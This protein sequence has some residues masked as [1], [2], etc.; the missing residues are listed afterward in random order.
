MKTFS[1]LIL[2]KLCPPE[3]NNHLY[4]CALLRRNKWVLLHA[5]L[6]STHGHSY[7]QESDWKKERLLRQ[8]CYRLLKPWVLN[9]SLYVMC[10]TY[11]VGSVLQHGYG[12][13]CSVERDNIYCGI[14]VGSPLI[15]WFK[16]SCQGFSLRIAKKGKVKTVFQI[17]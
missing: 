10:C 3:V 4:C 7:L 17:L 15:G 13:K 1:Q 14:I 5:F 6:K 9:F 11:G 16:T 8:K 12:R 2:L